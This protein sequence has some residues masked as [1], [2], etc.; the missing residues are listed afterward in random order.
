M[1]DFGRCKRGVWVEKEPVSLPPPAQTLLRGH[2]DVSVP[3]GGGSDWR[4][5]WHRRRHLEHR[6]SGE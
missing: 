3:L 4:R 1:L 6:L 2:P 5:L